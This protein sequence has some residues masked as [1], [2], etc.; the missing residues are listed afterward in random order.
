MKEL[1]KVEVVKWEKD[2]NA[3]CVLLAILSQVGLNI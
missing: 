2:A 1:K 3:V